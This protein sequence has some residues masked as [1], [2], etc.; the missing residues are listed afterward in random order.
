MF[1]WGMWL[2]GD[3]NLV[4]LG[5]VVLYGSCNDTSLGGG[6][7]DAFGHGDTHGCG[8]RHAVQANHPL[9]YSRR[10]LQAGKGRWHGHN[11]G[12][13]TEAQSVVAA[14][15]VEASARHGRHCNQQVGDQLH[16]FHFHLPR[17][18]NKRWVSSNLCCHFIPI[19]NNKKKTQLVTI[20]SFTKW[21]ITRQQSPRQSTYVEAI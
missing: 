2:L 15:R 18:N 6:A 12:C 3:V 20:D 21:W 9:P 5:I 14:G 19:N 11:S 7:F 16:A 1:A 10:Y 8:G 13:G 17:N 4:G